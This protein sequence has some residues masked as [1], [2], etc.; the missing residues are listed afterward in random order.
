MKHFLAMNLKITTKED[1]II[2]SEEMKA[3]QEK[4]EVERKCDSEE[5]KAMQEKAN[6]ERKSDKRNDSKN[7]RQYKSYAGHRIKERTKPRT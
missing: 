7:G 4:A 2:K 1:R 5:M 6:A 3:M